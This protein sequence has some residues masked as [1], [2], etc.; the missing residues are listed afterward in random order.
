MAD[1][2]DWFSFPSLSDDQITI[3]KSPLPDATMVEFTLILD[4]AITWWKELKFFDSN[5][6]VFAEVSN[7]DNGFGPY[8]FS[9]LA[10]NLDGSV[11]LISKAKTFGVHTGMYEI[12]DLASQAGTHITF[13]WV[14]DTKGTFLS[15]LVNGIVDIVTTVTN[16]ISTTVETIFGFLVNVGVFIADQF[17]AIPIVGRF[18]NELINLVQTIVFGLSSAIVDLV[19]A[20]VGSAPE[21]QLR[22]LI[23]IQRDESGN[24]VAAMPSVLAALE[25]A[26]V[27]FKQQANVRLVPVGPFQYTSKFADTPAATT[28]FVTTESDNSDA[29]TL[30]VNC[31]LAGWGDDFMEAGSQFEKKMSWDGFWGNTRRI[32]GYGAP[33]CVFAVRSFKPGEDGRPDVGCSMGPLSNYVTVN[34]NDS[35][36]P[37]FSTMAHELGHAC[38]LFHVSDSTN[39]MIHNEPHPSFLDSGQVFLLRTSRHV[40]FF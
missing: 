21:K 35:G 25:F 6:N 5:N 31:D 7:S 20:M 12:R 15:D 11:L 34:F 24:P 10:G 13:T 39:L 32:V 26:I 38:S 27:T 1:R 36:D 22:L 16:A 37:T 4:P 17:L 14:S 3:A 9:I 23:I 19:L 28:A 2:I 40:T 29:T 18:I 30:D 8:T 33:V